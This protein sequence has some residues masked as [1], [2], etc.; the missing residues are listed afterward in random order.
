MILNLRKRISNELAEETMICP[1]L[2]PLEKELLQKQVKELYRGQAWSD[3]CREWVYF[4]CI[5]LLDEVFERFHFDEKI[6]TRHVHLGKHEGSEAGFYCRIC[7]DGVMGYHP[8]MMNTTFPRK[9][10]F[11]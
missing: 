3:N 2:E 1:H 6:I 7:K 4:D 8:D 11:R 5:F 9:L 10:L